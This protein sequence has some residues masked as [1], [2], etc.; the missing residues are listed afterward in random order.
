[1]ILSRS[2]AQ[3]PIQV[4]WSR[5]A[6]L[7]LAAATLWLALLGPAWLIAGREGLLGVSAAALIC[8]VPGWIVFWIA[9]AY[10]TAGSQVPLVVLGGMLLRMIFVF[11]G[12]VI[13]QSADPRLGFRE[14]VVWLLA[15]YAVLLGVETFLVLPRTDSA[16]G[17]PRAGGA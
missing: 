5:C 15:F 1:M 17:Q 7:T 13:I 10:G 2:M 4:A 11:L 14:F 9:A 3:T 6:W 8:V 16:S 12:M